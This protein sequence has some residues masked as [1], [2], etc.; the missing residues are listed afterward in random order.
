[1]TNIIHINIKT[2]MY[3]R[4]FRKSTRYQKYTQPEHKFLKKERKQNK[5]TRE[6]RGTPPKN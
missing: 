3:K 6:Q 4:R 5:T 1:M 2:K